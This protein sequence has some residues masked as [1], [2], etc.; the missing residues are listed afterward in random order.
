MWK[1]QECSG[2]NQIASKIGFVQNIGQPIFAFIALLPF[3]Y[4]RTFPIAVLALIAYIVTLG[5]MVYKEL[6]LMKTDSYWCTKSKGNG[7]EWQ[8]ASSSNNYLWLVFVVS[9][10]ITMFTSQLSLYTSVAT[11]GSLLV[12]SIK[13]G[14][15]KS[16]GSWWCYYAVNLPYVQLV[17]Q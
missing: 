9:L 13:Y 3:L 17:S 10:A 16:V 11:L 7:L 1:D 8:W 4:K 5:W 15:T 14:G 2:L 12:S 6:P